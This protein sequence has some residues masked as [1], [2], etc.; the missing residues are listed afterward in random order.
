MT[1][2]IPVAELLRQRAAHMDNLNRLKAA[3]PQW[4][5]PVE[6]ARG[7]ATMANLM[8]QV[9]RIDAILEQI[10]NDEQGAAA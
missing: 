4:G 7:A 5:W 9:Y 10:E 8:D 3:E 6:A 1:P 2:F